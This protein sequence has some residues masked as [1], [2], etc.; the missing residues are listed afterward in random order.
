MQSLSSSG[1]VE[2]VGVVRKLHRRGTYQHN[3]R[4]WWEFTKDLFITWWERYVK[5]S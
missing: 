2:G 4:G 1:E 3:L 5:R